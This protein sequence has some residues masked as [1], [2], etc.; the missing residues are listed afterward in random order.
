MIFIGILGTFFFGIMALA[1][2]IFLSIL[3][4]GFFLLTYRLLRYL[5]IGFF[6]LTYRLL[7]YL[8]KGC[9]LLL[10][11]LGVNILA[12]VWGAYFRGFF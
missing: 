9:H 7:R 1:T 8:I 6:L 4:I 2:V 5:I 3:V 12:I 11:V 10:R